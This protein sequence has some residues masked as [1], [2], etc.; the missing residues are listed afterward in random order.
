MPAT[1]PPSN[2][3]APSWIVVL[4]TTASGKSDVALR[5]AEA[6]GGE[7]IGCDSMQ[8]YR[9]FDAGTAKPSLEARARVAH[10]MI[11]VA[12]PAQDFD[13]GTYTRLAEA[14]A[15]AILERGGRPV[16]AGGTG[17]YLQGLL[18]G[19]FDGPRRDE[20]FRARLLGIEARWPGHPLHRLLRR[21]DPVSARRL[22]PRDLQR[23]VR[24][25]E[26]YFATG[27]TLSDHFER[28]GAGGDRWPTIKI[29]LTVPRP[30]LRELI[31]VR[32]ARFFAGGWEDEVRALLAHGPPESANAWKALG[33]RQVASLV[34]GETSREQAQEAIVQE[35]LRYA[36]RQM[37]WFRRERDVTWFEH[38]GSPPFAEIEAHVGARTHGA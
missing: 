3:P 9:G 37:T 17:L 28:Q 19:L 7:V 34:R 32:V 23:L 14:A 10:H 1:G 27:R 12:D 31:A 30:R 6:V 33:Y 15:R 24:A 36:K 20:A 13:L 4:G 2:S 26:V 5:L 25:L 29:G 16:V 22:A 8:V 18:R 35:T 21:V 38:E 11:D